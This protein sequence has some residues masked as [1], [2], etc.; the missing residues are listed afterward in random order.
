MKSNKL[1]NHSAL[2]D[3]NDANAIDPSLWRCVVDLRGA[4]K[5]VW[6]SCYNYWLM[7]GPQDLLSALAPY[8][9]F[10]VCDLKSAF[11]ALPLAPRT[12][13][14]SL[15]CNKFISRKIKKFLPYP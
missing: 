15:W 8:T 7:S 13:R 12:A 11:R 2:L 9:C 3:K 14:K 6:N 10:I 4:N 5:T 1:C